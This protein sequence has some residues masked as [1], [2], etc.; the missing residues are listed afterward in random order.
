ML[1][2]PLMLGLF[3]SDYMLHTDDGKVGRFEL[4]RFCFSFLSFL[5]RRSRARRKRL[6]TFADFEGIAFAPLFRKDLF[7]VAA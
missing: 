5:S 4:Y 6:K 3:R 1:L 2:Q 7:F